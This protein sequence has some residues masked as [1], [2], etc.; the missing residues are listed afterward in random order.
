MPKTPRARQ[1]GFTLS[2]MAIVIVLGGI[3]LAAGLMAGRGQI[4]RAQAQ[5]VVQIAK[6]LQSGALAFRQRYGALPGDLPAPNTVLNG[7]A[8]GTG[9]ALG[10]GLV[11][12]AITGAGIAT[13]TTE[14]AEAPRQLFLAGL[15]GKIGTTN[16]NYINSAFGPVQITQAT[17][18]T[19]NAAYRAAFPTVTNVV[20]F[21]SLPCE[22][23]SEVDLMLDDG[24]FQTGRAQASGAA[25]VAGNV[26]ARYW[27]PL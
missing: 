5:D 6:D 7:A 24:G 20:I 23:V 27:V 10:N 9:G 16:T 1:Y 26:V 3:L 22:V 13:A 12:G 8:A 25:C 19:T 21:Y 11:E 14:V 4:S 15:I 17:N 18:P 2:E